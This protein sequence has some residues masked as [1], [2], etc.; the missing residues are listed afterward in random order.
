MTGTGTKQAEYEIRQVLEHWDF[1]GFLF[2][3]VHPNILCRN[4]EPTPRPWLHLTAS[5]YR[6]VFVSGHYL[7]QL[8]VPGHH[9]RGSQAR[10]V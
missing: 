2:G 10:H 3:S 6:F 8:Q 7:V 1:S 4:K 5:S 9:H